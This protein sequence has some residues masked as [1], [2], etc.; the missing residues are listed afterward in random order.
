MKKLAEPEWFRQ[1]VPLSVEARCRLAW[2]MIIVSTVLWPLTQLTV[3]RGEPPIIFALSW[4]A[5]IITACDLLFTTH[6]GANA[7]A[8]NEGSD[9]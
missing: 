7:E 6:A 4:F 3:G 2:T 8:A 1:P 5:I 9:A